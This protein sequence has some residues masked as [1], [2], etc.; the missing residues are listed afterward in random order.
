MADGAASTSTSTS[1]EINQRNESSESGENNA[2]YSEYTTTTEQQADHPQEGERL[3]RPE[4]LFRVK[5]RV[6]ARDTDTPLLY[7][8]TV[9]KIMYAPR[10][11]KVHIC[12]VSIDVLDNH[13][14]DTIDVDDEDLLEEVFG[15]SNTNRAHASNS[16]N[17]SNAGNANSA[18]ETEI[19]TFK[20]H[21][22]ATQTHTWHYFVH[23]QGWNV[24][25]DRWVD[26]DSLFDDKPTTRL[27][28]KKLK[29]ESKCLKKTKK[30]SGSRS[31]KVVMEVM[32]RIL[33]LEKEFREKEAKGES[34]DCLDNEVEAR[35]QMQS[36]KIKGANAKPL[37]AQ[38]QQQQQQQQIHRKNTNNTTNINNK[39][40]TITKNKK[41][42]EQLI[43]KELKLRQKDLSSKKLSNAVNLPFTL[44]KVLTDEWE[45]IQCG[46]VHNL[47]ARVTAKD[48]LDA[49]YKSKIEM[50]R[51]DPSL[52]VA[53]EEAGEADEA[54][55][56]QVPMSNN[57]EDD[58]LEE[59]KDDSTPTIPATTTTTNTIQPQN[60]A[61]QE[62]K[63]MTDGLAMYFDQSLSK[64][65]LYRQ[66][67]PQCIVMENYLY[68]K[69]KKRYCEIYP[70]E[71]LVRL[72]CLK[73]PELLIAEE[74]NDNKNDNKTDI[75]SL[76][77][78]ERNKILFKLGDFI[79]FLQKHQATYLLQRYRKL[80][81]EEREKAK[82]LQS[83]LGLV[84]SGVG[85]GGGSVG[86][87]NDGKNEKEDGK[88]DGVGGN[89]KRKKKDDGVTKKRRR[90]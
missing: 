1:E 32:Q 77:G 71:H 43:Q 57:E 58:Q 76:T 51:N 9:R 50:I 27:L 62:W 45:V 47:P 15:S 70:C 85:D 23:Y 52:S 42:K 60:A 84:G 89:L 82:K 34:L 21:S 29:D 25:W 18:S 72:C 66:E 36:K 35:K 55:T 54:A 5:Q 49:Y 75:G 61:E 2:T 63:D 59:K 26:E 17:A 16:S 38:Q 4:P 8:A 11:K 14:G 78:E 65:L 81:V 90:R 64:Q 86:G 10:S 13:T 22:S 30:K 6:L 74:E 3:L 33:R 41:A 68:T 46:M 31:D 28:A 83:K 39:K 44:K 24:N 67:V 79:R 48:A 19:E 40:S 87:G 20:S 73:L 7:D 80:T 53:T 56:T 12:R 69:D 37:H 88:E